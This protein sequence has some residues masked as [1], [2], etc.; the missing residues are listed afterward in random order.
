MNLRDRGITVGDLLL[1]IIFTISTIFIINKF[2]DS[3]SK[4]HNYMNLRKITTAK[5]FDY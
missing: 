1:T 4:A 5:I 2:Q 3:E